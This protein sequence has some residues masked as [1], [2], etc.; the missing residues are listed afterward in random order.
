LIFLTCGK[1]NDQYTINNKG[2]I[3]LLSD[4]SFPRSGHTATLLP[5]GKVLI[6][7]GMEKNKVFFNSSE[8]FNPETKK[9]TA[10][11]NMIEKR[12]GHSAV[13]LKNGKVLIAGGFGENG[14]LSSSE[15]YNPQNGS[16][17]KTG[18]MNFGRGDFTLTLLMNGDVLIT[19]GEGADNAL[20]SAEVYN[21]GT[22]IFTLT[23][24][25]NFARTM[26]TATLLNNGN[27][28]ITGGGTYQ[29]PS[30]SAEIYNTDSK[31]FTLSGS[32]ENPTYKHA[33]VKL[34]DGDVIVFGGSGG[35]DWKANYKSSETFNQQLDKFIFSGNMQKERFKITNSVVLLQ[36]GNILIVGGDK[37]SEIYN[38][39]EKSFSTVD[40]EMDTAR[41]YSTSTLL[42]NGC[43]LITGGYDYHGL[44]TSITWMFSE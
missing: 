14:I 43:V 20:K 6:T 10:T 9:F 21:P 29:N 12:V 11:G 26:H 44:S 39:K 15:I 40:G 27:V 33:A 3:E 8:I 35:G 23:D 30:S 38:V 24:N 18:S 19:G 42:N 1:S 34:I 32:M 17:E 7:G 31:A 16:F 37:L 5:D 25:M 22:G 4:M 13:L 36:S 2:K 28:L 41:F